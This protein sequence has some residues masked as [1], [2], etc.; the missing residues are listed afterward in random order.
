VNYRAERGEDK[1]I[2]L[3]LSVPSMGYYVDVGAMRPDVNSNTAFLRDLGWSGIAID[4]HPDCAQWWKDVPHVEFVCAVVGSENGKE[5]DFA[6]GLP[7][8]EAEARVIDPSTAC[9][10]VV[11]KRKMVS[12][13]ELLMRVVRTFPIQ[14]LSIDIEGHEY[15]ALKDF[16]FGL[17]SPKIVVAEYN[18]LGIGKDYRVLELLLATG[19]YRAVHQ[20][21]S[22]L[23]FEHK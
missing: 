19:K 14:F 13:Q 8:H 15:D 18:T 7:G 4:G 17:F 23:I 20:T 6:Y 21:E 10:R 9:G 22:N 1:W 16:D 3:N 12:L 2:F 5:V 11:T